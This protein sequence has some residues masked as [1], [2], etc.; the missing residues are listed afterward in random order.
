MAVM[1]HKPP[2]PFKVTRD[3]SVA[4]GVRWRSPEERQE[5]KRKIE[6]I[7]RA[8]ERARIENA[9][10][11]LD[12]SILRSPKCIL[13]MLGFLVILGA[14]VIQGVNRP[15]PTTVSALPQ[16]Q[17][18]ARRSL[19]AVATALTLYR[20]HTGGWPEQ[21]FG[22]YALARNYSHAPNWKGPYI[23]WAHKD[24][25]S[26]P[27]VYKM[28]LSPFEAPELYSCGPDTLPDTNDD[29]HVTE[30]DFTC[31]EGTWHRQEPV[32]SPTTGMTI[33]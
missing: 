31:P 19:Q 15:R 13:G 23:N 4:K 32:E 6:A 10:N 3:T 18:R 1:M 26:T 12:L 33:P 9:Q 11:T 30:D 25:W 27:Y 22:L 24:P 8:T 20:V 21:R 5:A 29:I 14:I 16:Q 28:P 2:K 17:H 7:R